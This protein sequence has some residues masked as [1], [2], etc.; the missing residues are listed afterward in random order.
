MQFE[1]LTED[2]VNSYEAEAEVVNE[3]VGV[4][5]SIAL[6]IAGPLLG[7]NYVQKN[8]IPDWITQMAEGSILY[9][10]ASVFDPTGLMSWP[11]YQIALENWK[12][13]ESDTKNNIMLILS[14]L[15]MIP[16]MGMGARLITRI[17]TFPG[18]LP[19]K[20]L[21]GLRDLFRMAG[22]SISKSTKAVD[23]VIPTMIAKL[24]GKTHKGVDAGVAFRKSLENSM[25]IKITD[26]AIEATAK[27]NGIT[28]AKGLTA[29]GATVKGAAAV[30]RPAA[31]A[32]RTATAIQTPV[33]PGSGG[34]LPGSQ[35]LRTPVIR[36]PKQMYG[37]IGGAVKPL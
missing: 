18:R 8:G 36:G 2:I 23:D 33:K 6:M 7:S 15:S 28:L 19:F 22:N 1:I 20:V 12:Q 3:G 11:Y 37:H 16:G 24:S 35:Q 27:R 26:D 9:R 21:R 29:A 5:F 10:I 14:M 34:K 31:R 17:L 4:I 13:D 30:V 32:S 25:G